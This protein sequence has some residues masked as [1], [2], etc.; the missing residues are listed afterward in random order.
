MFGLPGIA[1]LNGPGFG[2]PRRF[3][4]KRG[5]QRPKAQPAPLSRHVG[6]LMRFST[7]LQTFRKQVLHL[8]IYTRTKKYNIIKQEN[9]KKA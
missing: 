2:H 5:W 3:Q 7:K 9:R 6:F 1:G 4:A 8:F